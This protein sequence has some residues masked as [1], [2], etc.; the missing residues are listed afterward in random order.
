V[1]ITFI[2]VVVLYLALALTTILVLRALSRRYRRL[3]GVVE[4]EGPY[5][6]R[7]PTDRL[8][9]PKDELVP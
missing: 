6:P 5:S 4:H 2:S 8:E 9:P 3:D 7:E 1:W